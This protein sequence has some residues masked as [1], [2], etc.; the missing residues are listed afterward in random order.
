MLRER[1]RVSYSVGADYTLGVGNGLS[2]LGEWFVLD[3]VETP[4][5]PVPDL[6]LA[7]FTASYPLGPLNLFTG[8]YYRDVENRAD[9]RV[10]EW[11]HTRDR[12]RLHVMGFW[13]PS[14]VRVFPSGPQT[15]SLAGR[16]IQVIFVLSH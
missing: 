10:I 1:W 7:A 12:W 8:A 6:R 14:D 15:A 5:V 16:G 4:A 11:R 2:V 3:N 13:N 9:F